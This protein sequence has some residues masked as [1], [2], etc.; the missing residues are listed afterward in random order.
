[1][2]ETIPMTDDDIAW[3]SAY[4]KEVQDTFAT[5]F[6]AAEVRFPHWRRPLARFTEAVDHVLKDGRVY[7]SAVDEAH[8]ELCVA[9]AILANENPHIARLEYEPPLQDCKKSIDFRATAEDG[10]LYYVDVKTIKP[11]SKDRWDQYEK[12]WE[13]KWLPD[14]V[15]II[16]EKEWLGGEMWHSMFAARGRMLEYALELEAKIAE[17]MLSAA[18]TRIVM[19]FC[20]DG[21]YWH[22]SEL[23]DFVSFYCSGWHRADDPFS[24]AELKY[25]AQKALAFDRTFTSFACMSRPQ[26]II[27]QRPIRWNVQPPPDAFA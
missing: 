24:N 23:E 26:G 21:F 4:A 3:L 27:R 15:H 10:S 9:S 19:M 11:V 16:L 8:N 7:F 12:A 18:N 20:G 2:V 5:E 1:M 14:N 13:E 6:G 17:A 25:M 22:R